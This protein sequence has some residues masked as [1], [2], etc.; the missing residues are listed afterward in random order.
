MNHHRSRRRKKNYP[1]LFCSASN[2]SCFSFHLSRSWQA[3]HI[4]CDEVLYWPWVGCEYY[5]K[6]AHILILSNVQLLSSVSCRSCFGFDFY[7]GLSCLIL[8][9]HL[10]S[11]CFLFSCP[12]YLVCKYLSCL[13]CSVPMLVFICF[14]INVAYSNC[15]LQCS[16]GPFALFRAVVTAE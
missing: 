1:F 8:V 3:N 11:S 2:I 4:L 5:K 12:H 13:L 16:L 15:L 14:A 6:K 10:P 7:F 9:T